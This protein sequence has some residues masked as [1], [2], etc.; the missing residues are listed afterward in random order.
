MRKEI[1]LIRGKVN[2]DYSAFTQRIITTAKKAAISIKPSALKVTV[3]REAPPKF[4]IIP[5]RK[6]KIAVVSVYKEKDDSGEFFKDV[7]GFSGAFIVEEAIPVGYEKTWPDGDPTPGVCLL[8]LFHR[9]QG[10]DYDL[11]IDRW[12]NGHTPLSLKIHPLWNYNRNVVLQK[13]CEKEVWY[14]GIVEEQTRSKQELLN[15]FKFFGSFPMIIGNMIAVYKDVNSFIH[16]K[17]IE[18]Y[19]VQEYHIFSDGTPSQN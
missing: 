18:S 15:P 10:I 12:H 9:K 17:L 2:E 8:T 5:F 1:Y 16:Y 3:T 19:L 6:D 13:L 11:F 7:D 14:D 4:S